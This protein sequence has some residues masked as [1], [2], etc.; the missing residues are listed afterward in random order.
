MIDKVNARAN[1][2]T[3][4]KL[5]TYSEPRPVAATDNHDRVGSDQIDNNRRNCVSGAPGPAP[6]IVVDL[7]GIR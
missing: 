7:A 1:R 6:E 2:V 4:A 3:A 5:P